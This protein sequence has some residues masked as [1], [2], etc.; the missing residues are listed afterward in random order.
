MNHFDRLKKI[1]S[2][3]LADADKTIRCL[4][5]EIMRFNGN[6]N[7]VGNALVVQVHND[8]LGVLM[9]L[10]SSKS[11]DILVINAA[12]TYCAV[13]GGIFCAEAERRGL[14]GIVVDGFI[15]DIDYI[16][17]LE[18]PVYAK[19]CCPSAGSTNILPHEKTEILCGGVRII[20]GDILVGD[21]DG[22]VVVGSEN[23]NETIVAAAEIEKNE[24]I[25]LEQLKAGHRLSSLLNLEQ[26]IG[27]LEEN[28]ESKIRFTIDE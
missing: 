28:R 25:I 12:A 13:L 21:G 22:V 18:I 16:K 14:A 8:F 24:A 6:V 2:S 10:T 11:N 27:N 20:N 7:M 23:L 1:S 26:H 17:T 4:N 3:S 9:A 5:Q 19:G 15:R